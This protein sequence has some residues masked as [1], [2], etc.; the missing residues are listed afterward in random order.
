[1]DWLFSWEV[2]SWIVGGTFAAALGVLALDD[3]KLARVFFLIAAADAAGGIVMWGV[4]SQNQTWQAVL[5]VFLLVGSVGALTVLAFR[6]VDNKQKHKQ[7]KDNP[8]QT[9]SNGRMVTLTEQEFETLLKSQEKPLSPTT[10]KPSVQVPNEFDSDLTFLFYGSDKLYY[11]YRN[12]SEH[13]ASK[14]S[15][16]FGFMDLTNPYM[17][18]VSSGQPATSQPFPTL[19]KTLSEDFVRPGELQGNEEILANF[20][21]HIKNEDVIWGVAMI[22]CINCLKRRAYYVYWKVGAGGWYAETDYKKMELPAPSM[23]PYSEDQINKYVDKMVPTDKR[24]PINA[25]LGG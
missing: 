7:A 23:T 6:Y 20:M 8:T 10:S 9:P 12:T 14:P 18:S 5:A 2:S 1:M 19:A 4:K 25:T 22:S 17:Y 16:A 13:S 24:K 21:G 3:F 15:I 11:A